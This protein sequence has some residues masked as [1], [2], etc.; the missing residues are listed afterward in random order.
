MWSGKPKIFSTLK[1]TL[2]HYIRT[3]SI[4]LSGRLRLQTGFSLGSS[5]RRNDRSGQSESLFTLLALR[6]SFLVITAHRL[7]LKIDQAQQ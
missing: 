5:T 2:T 6:F 1:G 4:L 7:T 3:F